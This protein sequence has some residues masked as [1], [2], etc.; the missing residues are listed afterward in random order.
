MTQ[1]YQSYEAGFKENFTK[2]SNRIHEKYG[3]EHLLSPMFEKHFSHT[4][5]NHLALPTQ[6]LRYLMTDSKNNK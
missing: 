1:L 6:S 4:E 2:S 3:Y 5:I